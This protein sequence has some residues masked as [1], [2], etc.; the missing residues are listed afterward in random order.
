MREPIIILGA[1]PAGLV[2]AAA[3]LKE[4]ID[5]VVIE[6]K[7][8]PRRVVGESLLPISME[9][10]E[11]VGFLDALNSAGFEIKE[12][13]RFIKEGKVVDFSFAEQ[14]NKEARTWTWQVP[15][16]KFDNIL[17][18]ETIK[19]GGTIHFGAEIQNIDFEHG[20]NLK[21]SYQQNGKAC[22]LIGSFL[23]DSSG[24]GSV[25][26]RMLKLPV[27]RSQVPNWAIYTHVH[28]VNQS[29]YENAK[30]ISFE[31]SEIDLWFWNIP[32]SDGVTSLGF[33]G[34]K[35]H[36]DER[37]EK[38]PQYFN[39]LINKHVIYFKDRFHKTES[40]F[41]P[42]WYKGFSQSV[43]TLYG[44]KYVITG[45]C[46][47]FLDP[48]FSSGVALATT[49]AMQ[50]ARRIIDYLNGKDPDWE[51]YVK[52]MRHG[53][54]VFR[55][56]VNSWYSG[57]LQNI[58]FYEQFNQSIKNK[59]CSVLAGYVW[60]ESNEFVT[61]RQQGIKALSQIVSR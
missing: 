28:D 51:G 21:V 60:D 22:E 45:N 43:D 39:D 54:D 6:K 7:L 25:V 1:G 5:V 36:F 52:H 40:R 61:R 31:V 15:R 29:Q 50:S 27:D 9:H 35:R 14:F 12:G 17:A 23:V 48:V 2:T 41:H 10:F 19:M 53:I 34:H 24:F 49:S 4:G 26:P 11:S 30:R 42:E 47:E 13:A 20:E 55:F 33:V 16:D 57:D 38:D 37:R 8:F 32:F 44:D 18:E 59:I 3:L 58:F 56:Y 46:A